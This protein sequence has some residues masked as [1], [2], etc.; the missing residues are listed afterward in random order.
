ML[1]N[2]EWDIK[3]A[4]ERACRAASLTTTRMGAQASIPWAN[5][6]VDDDDDDDGGGGEV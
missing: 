4:V 6:I 1:H 5:E 2:H 3:L